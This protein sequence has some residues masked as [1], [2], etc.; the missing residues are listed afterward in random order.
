M[1]KQY[2]TAYKVDFVSWQSEP[3]HQQQGGVCVSSECSSTASSKKSVSLSLS[4]DFFIESNLFV[5]YKKHHNFVKVF[6]AQKMK[7]TLFCS[8]CYSNP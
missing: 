6:Y 1:M 8:S 3:L 7:G 4:R 2:F 5:V